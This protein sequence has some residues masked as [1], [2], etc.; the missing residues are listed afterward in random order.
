MAAK[1]GARAK[2]RATKPAPKKLDTTSATPN[3][4]A[5]RD[6]SEDGSTSAVGMPGQRKAHPS[7]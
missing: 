1:K 3:S 6:S 5:A 2:T 7:R 4:D